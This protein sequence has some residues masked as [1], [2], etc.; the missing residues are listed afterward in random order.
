MMTALKPID[1]AIKDSSEEPGRNEIEYARYADDLPLACY[2][3]E[4][5]EF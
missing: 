1:R 5:W 4:R 2:V 3:K